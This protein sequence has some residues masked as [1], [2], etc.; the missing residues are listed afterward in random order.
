MP[1]TI[2]LI[3]GFLGSGKT[4]ALLDQL[5]KRRGT[6]K[7]AILV[8]DFGDAAIDEGTLQ[9]SGGFVMSE[10][11]GACVC[12]TAPEGFV[13][14]LGMLLDGEPDRI[15]IE[16]T[17]LAKP[18]DLIDTIRRSKHRERAVVGLPVILVDPAH[19][20]SSNAFLDEIAEAAGTLVA[21]KS[22][23]ATPAQMDAFRSW[24]AGLWPRPPYVVETHHGRIDVDVFDRVFTGAHAH[25]D[26]DHD[27][28]HA[29]HD[30]D[31]ADHEAHGF[32]GTS[33]FWPADAVFSRERL[34]DA[35]AQIAVGRAGALSR[36]KGV[37]RTPE[38][39]FRIELAGG[40]VHE[41]LTGHRLDSRVDIV[42][43]SGHEGGLEQASTWLHEALL[44]AHELTEAGTSVEL[45]RAD[46]SRL[47][48]DRTG[49]Q[50]LPNGVPDVAELLP[51]RSGAAARMS[52]LLDSAGIAGDLV[53]V[54]IASDGY[55]TPAVP[56]EPL[57]NGVL[58]HSL[59]DGALPDDKGG[60][61][62]LL[63]PGD[64]GPA[65]ACSNVKGVVRIVFR[66]ATPTG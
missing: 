51:K 20:S 56:I 37:F 12:C 43:Q 62:R 1:S 63:I 17:G 24:A 50:A 36:L 59:A 2:N 60:P 66:A 39:W 52:E 61:F 47:S 44:A 55:A 46:G 4:T 40:R 13:D 6:E 41:R 58:L 42:L 64:A 8:N 29:D 10:I 65:G 22:D 18:A 53:A 7:I 23:L 32:A 38:G 9:E 49:L 11:R 54:V 48:L 14:A 16:P 15:F 31:H 26:H 25:H 28:D 33:L 5:E 45:V 35:L 21:N 30:H 3:A 19:L 57:R 34:A 27:H